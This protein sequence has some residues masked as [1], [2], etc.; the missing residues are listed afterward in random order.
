MELCNMRHQCRAVISMI[1]VCV[2]LLIGHSLQAQYFVDIKSPSQSS[3]CV[4]YPV[5]VVLTNDGGTTLDASLFQLLVTS[6]FEYI[7]GSVSNDVSESDPFHEDGPIFS[8]E[9]IPPC[10]SISFLL[11]LKHECISEDVEEVIQ[12]LWRTAG[13]TETSAAAPIRLFGVQLSLIDIQIYLDTLDYK[14]KKAYTIVNSGKVALQDFIFYIDGED[15]MDILSTSSGSLSANGDTIYFKGTDY[16]GFGNQNMF[17]EPGESFRVVHEIDLD[18]CEEAFPFVHLMSVDCGANQCDFEVVSASELKVTI[19]QPRLIVLQQIDQNVTPCDSGEIIL[20]LTNRSQT[21][22]FPQANALYNLDMNSGWSFIRNSR[23]TD[24]LRDNCLRVVAA[25][26][27]GT[28]IPILTQGYTGYGLDFTRLTS[29]PDGPGGLSDIDGDG[30][31]DDLHAGDTICL[32]LRYVLRT[33]CLNIKCS[34]QVFESRIFRILS[35][36]D[37]YCDAPIETGNYINR[38]NYYWSGTGG[39][40]GGLDGIYSDGEK[41]TLSIRLAKSTSGFLTDCGEDSAV[42]RITLPIVMNLPPGA[43]ILVNGDTA[44]YSVSGRRITL[45]ADTNRF[46][47]QIPIELEC[48][49]NAGGG[50]IQTACTFCLGS[51]LPKYRINVE[52]DYFCE[53]DCVGKIPLI[54]FQ[55]PEFITVCDAGAKGIVSE[56]KFVIDDMQMVRQTLGYEDS[57][58]QTKVVANKDSLDLS[59]LMSF[60]TFLLEIPFDIRCDANYSNLRFRLIQNSIIRINQG[61]RDTSRYFK[62]LSDTIKYYDE[63]TNRWSACVNRLGNEYFNTQNDGYRNNY[64][65]EVNLSSQTCLRGNFSIPD[66]LVIV[67]RGVVR[68]EIGNNVQRLNIRGDLTYTQDGCSQNDRSALQF[69][70]FSGLPNPGSV[71]LYQPYVRDTGFMRYYNVLSVCGTF[72]LNT[73]LDNVYY[74]V[75]TIDPF[76]NEFRKPYVIDHVQL[77]IPDFFELDSL[78]FNYVQE[79]YNS[80]TRIIKADTSKLDFRIRDS[81]SYYV[82]DFPFDDDRDFTAV[83]HLLR[84]NMVPN[85]YGFVNDTIR[86]VKKFKVQQQGSA[87]EG[88]D[89]TIYQYF[90]LNIG[91]VEPIIGNDRQQFLFDSMSVTTFSLNPATAGYEPKDYFDF[92]HT[93]LMLELASDNIRIDSLIE[94]TDSIRRN[95][96]PTI[97]ADGRSLYELDT[98]T[99]KRDFKLYSHVSACRPD[100]IRL[101]VGTKCDGYPTDWNDGEDICER[102][103]Q[104]R[105][106]IILPETP[107]LVGEFLEMPDSS[108]VSPCDTFDYLVEFRNSNLGHLNEP[109]LVL[110]SVDGLILIS[111]E[112]EYPEGVWQLLAN[113]N[114]VGNEMQWPLSSIFDSTGFK[115]FFSPGLNLLKLRLSFKG[116]CDVQDGAVVAV[117]MTGH[118]LCSEQVSSGPVNAIPLFFERDSLS[119]NEDLYDIDLRFKGDTLCGDTFELRVVLTSKSADTDVDGQRLGLFYRKELSYAAG[120]FVP[121]RNLEDDIAGL[122]RFE[123]WEQIFIDLDSGVRLGDSIVFQSKF[124]RTCIG[125]CKP[126]DLRFEILTPKDI[127]C[128]TTPSGS[129]RLLLNSQSWEFDEIVVA[130]HYQISDGQ[131]V[132]ER[133]PNGLEQ[134][135]ASFTIENLSSFGIK[136][137]L[138]IRFYDDANGNGMLDGQDVLLK[139]DS[140]DGGQVLAFEKRDIQ[141]ILNWPVD[142]SC[143]LIAS[144]SPADNPCICLADTIAFPPITILP[145]S[146]Y[147]RSCYSNDVAVG[148]PEIQGYSYS[149]LDSNLVSE[150]RRSETD[151]RFSGMISKTP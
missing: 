57:T 12:G 25:S 94:C 125:I 105:E 3:P 142:A 40:V 111:A 120:S 69:N 107:D 62:F 27:S 37:D 30:R 133:M 47:I 20:K 99:E 148:F 83:R 53:D 36:Y 138:V 135:S 13:T 18:A 134:Y 79:Y 96:Q 10:E 61:V 123:E 136:S 137:Q 74:N 26:V 28:N 48:D 50:T 56:G 143:N 14:F 108:H 24:P 11:W 39:S 147:V 66:S 90:P 29:D 46:L 121:I 144:I 103:A 1:L 22:S 60:D 82:V 130:P 119:G 95:L 59:T 93:W 6:G 77:I 75:D 98:T 146:D 86:V 118:D 80:Q 64:I 127:G 23:R 44:V 112:L 38:H 84:M 150:P 19:G 70:V 139:T 54:C 68:N 129:C 41:D 73:Y 15:N 104:K 102:Y 113:P 9:E 34:G 91:A 124:E 21:G 110:D 132:I 140:V 101:T 72:E 45:S 145:Q 35:E 58:K 71:F 116:G 63:E 81:L 43:I 126:T 92:H 8:I 32:K 114:I 88:K 149:W 122:N 131:G 76:K 4:D 128:P 55:S 17:F 2:I 67:V 117:E 87:V 52:M 5:E 51:G 89:S 106:I 100:T 49:P 141:S 151:Y 31:F 7:I 33:S 115:G 97:L 78:P 85:C 42:V 65:K 16:L 109:I